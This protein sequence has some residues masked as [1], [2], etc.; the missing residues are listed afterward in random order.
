MACKQDHYIRASQPAS[1]SEDCNQWEGQDNRKEPCQPGWLPAR[2]ESLTHSG[3]IIPTLSTPLKEVSQ[4]TKTG[5][6]PSP[7][8]E[9]GGVLT[10]HTLSTR[11]SPY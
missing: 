8:F 9:E 10:S 5:A 6:L 7:L 1:Q 11:V 4:S 2:L 3:Q